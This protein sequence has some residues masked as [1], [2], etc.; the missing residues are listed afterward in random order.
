MANS[1]M[2]RFFMEVAPPQFVSVMRHRTPKMLDTISEEEKDVSGS[3]ALA[4]TR[5]SFSSCSSASSARAS[6]A[7][8]SKYFL[9]GVQIQQNFSIF[10][11]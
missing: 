1:R 11:N 2:A 8:D 7:C 9:Q 5:R 3:D 4:S 10:E 6:V